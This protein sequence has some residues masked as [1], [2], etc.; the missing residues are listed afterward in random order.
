MIEKKLSFADLHITLS[1][2]YESMGYADAVPDE[3]VKK[4]ILSLL[5]RIEA[6]A[7]PCFYFFLSCGKLE[8]GEEK[9]IINDTSFRIGRIIARQLHGSE[10]FAFFAATVGQD[11]EAF[12]HELQQEGD[13]VKIYITDAIGSIIAEKAADCMEASLDACISNEGW[14][15]T[16]RF[17]PGYCGWHVSE[18]KKLFPLFPVS[19]PC[20]IKLTESSL[21]LPIKSVSGVIGVG[22][23]VRKTAYTCGLCT[24][25]KCYRRKSRK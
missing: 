20:G 18:Q 9:L 24:Y 17:S 16:N 7:H 14:L 8:E 5:H 10:R 2:I 1:E 21:M 13:M 15:H 11:F 12:Q 6:A 23:K 22:E 25:D 4:E 3:A 19:E